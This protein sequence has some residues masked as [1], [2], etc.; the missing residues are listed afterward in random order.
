[1]A[2]VFLSTV[3]YHT[4]VAQTVKRLAHEKKAAGSKRIAI[5]SLDESLFFIS[6]SRYSF[7]VVK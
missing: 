4:L 6:I 2:S 3:S 1:M 7:I 5:S